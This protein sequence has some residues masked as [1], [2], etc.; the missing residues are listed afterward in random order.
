MPKTVSQK[1][2]YMDRLQISALST[3]TRI[4]IYAWEQRILQQLL[5]DIDIPH[6]FSYCQDNISNTLDYETLCQRVTLFVES[7][8]FNLIE[9]VAEKIVLLI[10]EE[11]KVQALTVCVSK[12][13]AIKNAR[14]ISV[15]I[16]R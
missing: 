1:R 9:T 13:H 11:F 7:N 4:G 14:N 8:T 2:F 16:H 3:M 10:K 12:P 6:D 5:I 15:T